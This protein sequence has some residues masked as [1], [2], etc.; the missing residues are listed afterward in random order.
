MSYL[1]H[2]V[3]EHMEGN[4]LYPLNSLKNI[5]PEAY[6]KATSKYKDRE[7]VKEMVVPFFNCLWN[8]VLHL[9]AVHPEKIKI[10]LA[11]AGYIK[12][13]KLSSYEINPSILNSENTLIYL[14]KP[15]LKSNPIVEENFITFDQ[16]KIEKYAEIPE[17]T[18]EY[19]KRQINERKTPLMFP[20]I[21]HFLYRGSINIENSKIVTV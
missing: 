17:G 10:A 15:E 13:F 19:Y 14:C 1:Y 3:P 12:D 18:K 7:H 20:G 9:S 21:V 6:E 16:N 2:V 11:E 5:Y 8:D 4:I